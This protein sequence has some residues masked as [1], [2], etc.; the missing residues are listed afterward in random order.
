MITMT[1]KTL[2]WWKLSATL[3]ERHCIIEHERMLRPA[4]AL[5]KKMWNMAGSPPYITVEHYSVVDYV[6]TQIYKLIMA[7]VKDC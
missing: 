7:S 1:S 3:E 5:L 4:D 6:N 2:S